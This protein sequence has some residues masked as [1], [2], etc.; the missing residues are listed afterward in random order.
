MRNWWEKR[1]LEAPEKNNVTFRGITGS[2][3]T[4]GKHGVAT[5]KL[6]HSQPLRN[7]K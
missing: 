6:Q 7:E 4:L 5:Q 1:W 2:V 3:N